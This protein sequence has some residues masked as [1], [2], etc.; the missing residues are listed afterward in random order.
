MKTGL[1]NL[2][3]SRSTT[4]NRLDGKIITGCKKQYCS[5]LTNEEEESVVRFVKNKNRCLQGI[6]KK[7]LTNLIL[8]SVKIRDYGNKKFKGGRRYN[9]LSVNAKRA[10][11]SG[12]LSRSLILEK[13]G[14]Q[15]R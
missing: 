6:N 2:I 8:D 4:D 11:Q 5:I 9:S 3:K 12:K 13:V 15:S 1:S 14:R 10:L 7:G